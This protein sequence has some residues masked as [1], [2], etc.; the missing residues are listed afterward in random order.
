MLMKSLTAATRNGVF[1]ACFFTRRRQD[2]ACSRAPRGHRLRL[3]KKIRLQTLAAATSRNT[4][5]SKSEP[6]RTTPHSCL[7]ELPS[8]LT[9]PP[10]PRSTFIGDKPLLR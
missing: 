1:Q 4:A 3:P 9:H 5:V 7:R 10:T 2:Q 8:L 6:P